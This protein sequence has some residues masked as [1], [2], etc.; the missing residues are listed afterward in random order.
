MDRLKKRRGASPNEKLSM[1][2]LKVNNKPKH[3]NENKKKENK[4][5]K[6]EN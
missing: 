6:L 3:N 4:A 2:K 1:I 5:V